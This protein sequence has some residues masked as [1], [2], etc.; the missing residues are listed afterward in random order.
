M[1]SYLPP[2]AGV[3]TSSDL[4]IQT[5][6]LSVN[7]VNTAVRMLML[8]DEQERFLKDLREYRSR[9]RTLRQGSVAQQALRFE[10]EELL[11]RRRALNDEF[12][13]L[14][15]AVAGFYDLRRQLQ[16]LTQAMPSFE[17]QLGDL[18]P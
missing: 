6:F 11:L 15:G 3:E 18:D 2:A 1:N 17:H 8:V 13:A 14:Y 4:Q 10:A 9:L 16:A 12:C 5:D 7:S